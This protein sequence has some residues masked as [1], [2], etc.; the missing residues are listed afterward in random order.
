M[1]APL[2]GQW[3]QTLDLLLWVGVLVLLSQLFIILSY[4]ILQ[5]LLTYAEMQVS[6]VNVT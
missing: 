2:L 6:L 5:Q 3:P 4:N 1:F